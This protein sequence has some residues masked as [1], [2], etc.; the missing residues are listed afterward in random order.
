M[1]ELLKIRKL[2]ILIM[3]PI[4]LLGCTDLEEVPLSQLSATEFNQNEDQ[5]GAV[6]RGIISSFSAAYSWRYKYITEDVST[7]IGIIPTRNGGWNSNGERDYNNHTWTK[8]TEY[9]ERV[10]GF[11]SGVIG[12]AN[13]ALENIDESA[14]PSQYA[15]A[16]FLRALAYMELLN[17]YGNVPIVTV[18]AQDP[19][20]LAGNTPIGEQRKNVFEFVESEMLLA[21]TDLPEKAS[22]DASHYPRPVKESA[23][24]FLAK[25]YLNAEVYSGVSHWDECIEQCNNVIASGAYSLTPNISDSFI[26]EN[27]NS[28]EIMHAQPKTSLAGDQDTGLI[29]SQVQY[30]PELAFK[31]NLPIN[32]WGGFSVMK[33]HFDTYDD[34]DYRKTLILQGPQ[35]VDDAKTIPLYK[36]AVFNSNGDPANGQ[37]EIFPIDDITEAPIEQGFKSIKYIPDPNSIGEYANNDDV[38]LRYADILLSKA[39][40]IL[41]GGNDSMG[42]S[43]ADLLNVVRA[44]NF[45]PDK[46]ITNPTLSDILNER[47][48][49]FSLEGQRRTDLIR[50]GEYTSLDY[51]F[52]VNND[53]Y[54][55]LFPIPVA[56][57]DKNPKLEQNPGYN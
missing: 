51:K 9:N 7:D 50:F 46:P 37:F 25:L 44:R 52:K 23:Q 45:D 39:E 42:A 2:G 18:S 6:I 41:R 27:Q 15:E 32:G 5:V 3:I 57:L 17:M 24:G 40:A 56:E 34:D 35:W 4:M 48:W 22:V 1:K 43:A 19:N 14:F 31:Y 8:S 33:D 30:Q 21:I 47:A 55:N 36:G 29:F 53:S 54:R 28:P 16:R 11:Y 20:N 49:E 12:R 10:Y 26:P 38:I 13:F